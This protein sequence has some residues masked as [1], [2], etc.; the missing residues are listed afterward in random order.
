MNATETTS[1]N[2]GLEY[3]V[4]N[5]IAIKR[6]NAC[7]QFMAKLRKVH[8]FVPIELLS[9]KVTWTA[10]NSNLLYRALVEVCKYIIQLELQLEFLTCTAEISKNIKSALLEAGMTDMEFAITA[11]KNSDRYH[12]E[13]IDELMTLPIEEW[14][15]F[16]DY[17]SEL[18]EKIS[19]AY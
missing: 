12:S 9:E 1:N 15:A 13:R 2:L 4:A 10:E 11:H 3:S 14:A 7:R 5:A 16:N 17:M 18:E 8:G 6:D 19:Q